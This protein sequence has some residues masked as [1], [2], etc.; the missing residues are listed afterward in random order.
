MRNDIAVS[1]P[2]TIDRPTV[3]TSFVPWRS[4]IRADSGAT[5]IIVR[6]NGSIR[7]PAWSGL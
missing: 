2:A 3:T 6:A 5:T 7:M 1:A 4:T